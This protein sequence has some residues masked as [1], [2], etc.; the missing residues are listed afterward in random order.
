MRQERNWE[1]CGSVWTGMSLGD[2]QGLFIAHIMGGGGNGHGLPS[3]KSLDVT[4]SGSKDYWATFSFWTQFQ[5]FSQLKMNYIT[6][7]LIP[8]GKLEP[9]VARLIGATTATRVGDGAD[10]LFLG[11]NAGGL[12]ETENSGKL[13]IT[14]KSTLKWF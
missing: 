13:Y 4:N 1:E 9:L 14:N 10:C 5:S 7:L 6:C 3:H 2:A 12:E 11:G 8:T